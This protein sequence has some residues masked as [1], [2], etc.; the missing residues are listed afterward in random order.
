MK[1]LCEICLEYKEEGN[2]FEIKTC[3][4]SFCRDCVIKHVSTKIGDGYSSVSCLTLN[5][6]SIIDFHS[7]WTM[8]PNETAEKWNKALC[9]V[10]YREEEKVVC[11]FKD[12]SVGMIVE[13]D[14]KIRDCECPL[15]HRLFCG[16]CRVPWHEGVTC[17]D[18]KRLYKYEE[19]RDEILMKKLASQMKWMKCPKCQLF[20]EKVSGC[21]HITCRCRFEFCYACG[22]AWS[23]THG[24]CLPYY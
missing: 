18:Y 3:L 6:S 16:T 20:V 17:E 14:A 19:G 23:S 5:C 21:L 15:C 22:S 24:G 4:H 10:V 1:K 8:L 2:M 13:R 12:C 11:P 9:E 7:C